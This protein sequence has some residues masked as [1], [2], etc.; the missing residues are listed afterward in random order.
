MEKTKAR[1]ENN[2]WLW[3]EAPETFRSSSFTAPSR[4]SQKYPQHGFAFSLLNLVLNVKLLQ[5][6]FQ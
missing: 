5:K 3:H 4:F 6:S 1:K 2:G